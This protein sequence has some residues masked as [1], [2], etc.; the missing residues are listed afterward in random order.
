MFLELREALAAEGAHLADGARRNRLDHALADAPHRLGDGH[1]F[2]LRSEGARYGRAPERAMADGAR[3]REAECARLH[4]FCDEVGH[5]REFVGGRVLVGLAALAHHVEAHRSMRDLRA[6]IEG[7]LTRRQVVHV[8]GEALPAAPF[9]AVGEGRA[10]NVLDA[11]HEFDEVFLGAGANGRETDAAIPHD[12][13]ADAVREGRIHRRVPGHLAVVVR[14]HVDP[15]GRDEGAVGIH[16]LP[17]LARQGTD[18]RN[19]PVLDRDVGGARG[20]AR[21]VDDLAAL[22]EYVVHAVSLPAQGWNQDPGP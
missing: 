16:G 10:G 3:G 22:D 20:D 6:H 12:H 18:L 8:L 21:S 19:A 5:A 14:V 7:V 1:E 13:R 9:D 2:F 17:R 4:G 11:L 15:S